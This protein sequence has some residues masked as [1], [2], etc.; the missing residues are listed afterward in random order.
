MKK[1]TSQY[2]CVK[3]KTRVRAEAGIEIKCKVCGQV[4]QEWIK[5]IITK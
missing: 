3:D 2:V 1:Q 4:M 5:G